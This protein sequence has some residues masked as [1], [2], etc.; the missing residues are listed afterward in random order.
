MLET[1]EFTGQ[2]PPE[3]EITAFLTAN[4][5]SYVDRQYLPQNW[6]QVALY[7]TRPNS[8]VP[9]RKLDRLPL[10]YEV[11]TMAKVK[12]LSY[13]GCQCRV[14]R[15]FLKTYFAN[16]VLSHANRIFTR[17]NWKQ[18]IAD[19]S[20]FIPIVL[21][22]YQILQS[23]DIHP[24]KKNSGSMDHSLGD[25]LF[26]PYK[27]YIAESLQSDNTMIKWFP[28]ASTSVDYFML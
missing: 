2:L 9:Q 3:K 8:V 20:I 5:Q 15:K 22:F 24:W 16:T 12:R 10:L 23:Q 4:H 19:G 28:Q 7:S 13:L 1:V 25:D 26:Q 21:P 6:N 17:F 11:S 14:K 27:K 18:K